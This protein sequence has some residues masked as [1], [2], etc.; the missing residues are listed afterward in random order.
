LAPHGGVNPLFAPLF[1][2][3]DFPKV[4][5]ESFSTCSVSCGAGPN[6]T[7][8]TM[9]LIYI[10]FAVIITQRI[11]AIIIHFIVRQERGVKHSFEVSGTVRLI[12]RIK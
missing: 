9:R 3:V 11:G 12:G 1:P 6:L 5:L 4:E 2:K 7:I 10:I 8:P